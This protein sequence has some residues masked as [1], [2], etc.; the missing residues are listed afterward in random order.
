MLVS[1]A[2]EMKKKGIRKISKPQIQ[3]WDKRTVLEEF[4]CRNGFVTKEKHQNASS[5][6]K[7]QWHLPG[8]TGGVKSESN[9]NVH[10]FFIIFL[11]MCCSRIIDSYPR[12]YSCHSHGMSIE[13]SNVVKSTKNETFAKKLC[14]CRSIP[15]QTIDFECRRE[16]SSF[17][18]TTK[19]KTE[20][21]TRK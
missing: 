10:Y 17:T 12:V 1:I 3:S 2:I 14:D 11:L 16:I 4:V 8:F 18:T 7:L 21:K 19:K 6:D 5:F 20:K 9:I 13:P 15:S